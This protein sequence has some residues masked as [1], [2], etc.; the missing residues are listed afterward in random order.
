MARQ[1]HKLNPKRIAAIK[2]PGLYGDGGGLGL[3][4]YPHGGRAWT[5]RYMIAGKAREMGLGN[6]GDVSLARAR[7]LAAMARA[8]LAEGRDPLGERAKADAERAAEEAR[9]TTFESFARTFIGRR[10]AEWANEK[11]AAQWLA[12]LEAYAF[13]T[14]GKVSV[15]DVDTGMVLELLNAVWVSKPETARR[16]RGRIETILDAA[17]V[18][19]KRTGEN[20]ARWRGHLQVLLPNPRKVRVV[21]HHASLGYAALPEF[22]A[23]LRAQP[24]EAARA[25]RFAI[26]TA[27]RTG[28]II[29][30]TWSEIDLEKREW[31]VP[32]SR[33]KAKREHRVPLSAE[34]I[35]ILKEQLALRKEE[36]IELSADHYVFGVPGQGLSNGAMLA[37][38][39][40][41]E[42]SGIITPHGFRSTFRTWTAEQTAYPREIAEAAL[43]HANGDEVEAAYQRSDFF[44]R[45]RKLMAEWAEFATSPAMEKPKRGKVVSIG[46]RNGK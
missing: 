33:M 24:G 43:A 3:R 23:K 41:M 8:S 25:L 35:A 40:R 14:I 7:E 16:V 26:L 9:A 29:G 38:I 45:R 1:L 30:A 37:L 42:L 15:A 44:E 17:R 22:M 20:P 27:A 5:L 39:N 12:T 31:R 2:E 21:L 4:V 28:E 32:A 11:H 6:A 10:K 34:A 18:E 19:G 13:P 36:K 46:A